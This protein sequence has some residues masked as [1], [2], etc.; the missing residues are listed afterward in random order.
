MV[1]GITT[2]PAG[3]ANLSTDLSDDHPISFLYSAALAAADGELVN[4]AVLPGPVRLENGKVQCISCHDPHTNLFTD[5]LV[6]SS[7]N[8]SL[9]M[10]C[11]QKNLWTTSTHRTSTAIWSGSGI[12]PWPHT[13]YSTVSQNGCENC[14]NPHTAVG[15]PRLLNSLIEENNCMN[16]HNG[17]VATTNIQVQLTKA[18]VHDVVAYLGVHDP[19]ETTLAST[20]H[21]ECVDCHNP[22]A[23]NAGTANAPLANGFIAGVMGIDQNGNAVTQISFEYEL[24]Y[25]CHTSSPGMAS[26]AVSRQIV[27]NNVRLE[28]ATT[29]PSFHPVVGP[30]NKTDVPSLI[31]PWTS[32]SVMY[33]TDCHASDGSSSPDGPHGSIY[34]HI[35]KLQYQ[36]GSNVQ[37][38]AAAYAL[39]Y[40]CHSRTSIL[41]DVSF[42]RH[43]LH[44]VDEHTPCITC[45]DAHG[46]SSMQGNSLNNSNLI[47]FRLGSGGP[48]PW[49]NL[50]KYEDLGTYHGQCYMRC[51]GEDHDPFTY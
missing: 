34:P 31:F 10:A 13:S 20:Y 43:H 11:H 46:I 45:H 28:F 15:K 33:C 9:C 2:M 37:E 36:M 6:I 47:N 51:H 40:S 35:L 44:I 25:R 38:S 22:H 24:C 14:H 8:S 49:N 21:V 23:S 26:P 39:C 12:D 41:N 17:N 3:N 29:N 48:T 32:S 27:Q 5:F 30:R 18:Y 19:V 50:L 16:C 1:S 7:E 4:P 42:E